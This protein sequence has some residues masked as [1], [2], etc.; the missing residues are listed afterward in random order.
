[1]FFT[2]YSSQKLQSRF[3]IINI[4]TPGPTAKLISEFSEVQL[5]PVIRT[6]P[7]AATPRQ[8]TR[9]N[10]CPGELYNNVHDQRLGHIDPVHP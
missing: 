9:R 8:K 10:S 3:S 4:Y 6:N 5:Y 7:A 2:N 1:M